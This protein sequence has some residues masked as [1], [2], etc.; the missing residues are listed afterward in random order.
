MP[1]TEPVGSCQRFTVR[2]AGR[3]WTLERP[4]DLESLWQSMDEDDS[5]AEEHIPYWVELWP[6][7]LAL[8]N[9]LARQDL[10]GRRCLDLGCGLGLSALVASNLGAHVTGMD[11]ERDAL[12]FAARNARLNAVPQPLWLCMDW[13]RPGFAPACFERIWGGDIFYEQRF[14][15]PLEILLRRCLAPGGRVWF[16]DPERTVS[17]TVWARFSRRGWRVKNQ[18]QEV[19]PFDQAR[20]TVNVWELS[21]PLVM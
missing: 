14:F 1:T 11:Y 4:A 3:T 15:D 17:S 9:W 2:A 6:A 16:G 20:M 10:A 21:R 7:T 5:K 8:C 19:V 18:G 13:N 12:Y